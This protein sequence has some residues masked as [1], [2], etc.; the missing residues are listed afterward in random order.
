L[1]FYIATDNGRDV[2][3]RRYHE[4]GR[5]TLINKLDIKTNSRVEF[6]DISR[7]V[8]DIV[9]SSG[10]KNGICYIFSKHTTAGITVNEHAD[11]DVVTD[12]IEQLDIMVPQ[13]NRYHHSEGNSPAHIKASL[14]GD[15]E[16]LFI[17]D[18]RIV[19]GTWQGI[20]FCEFDGPRNR[21]VLVKIV[22]DTR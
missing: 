14:M 18:G 20:F 22:P 15:S 5:G 13:H 16:I 7:K 9:A 6:Q 10:T 21:T 12:I 8:G 11:P 2:G 3:Y 19:L 17:E 4:S 1:S